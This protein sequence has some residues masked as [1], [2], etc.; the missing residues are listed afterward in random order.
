MHRVFDNLSPARYHKT[1]V[2]KRYQLKEGTIL[3]DRYEL[4]GVLGEG[5]FGIT[6]E[7]RN[8]LTRA[9]VAIKEFFCRDYMDRN[10]GESDAM[11]LFDETMADRFAKDKARFLKEARTLRDFAS[12]DHVV[13]IEEYFELNGTAYIVMAYLDGVTLREHVRRT[14]KM[15]PEALFRGMKPL[16]AAL[17]R[18]HDRGLVHRDISP[19][20]IMVLKDGALCL[21][22]FGAANRY[23]RET[24]SYSVICKNGYA[25]PEQYR[26]GGTVSPAVD[27]Y[28]LAAT[29]YFCLTGTDPEDSLQRVLLDELPLPSA[30]GVSIPTAAEQILAAALSLRPESRFPDMKALLGA[31]E[32]VYPE[33]DNPKLR[34]KRLAVAVLLIAAAAALAVF[35]PWNVRHR[36]EIRFRNIDTAVIWLADYS[37]GAAEED[38]EPASLVKERLEVFAGKNNYLWRETE[39]EVRIEFPEELLAGCPPDDLCRYLLSRPTGIYVS[40]TDSDQM[41]RRVRMET[42]V[43]LARSRIERITEEEGPVTGYDPEAHGISDPSS[44]RRLHVVLSADGA[45]ELSGLLDGE[46]TPFRVYYD[47]DR[48]WNVDGSPLFYDLCVSCGD[49]RSFDLIPTVQAPHLVR[50]L[51]YDL[52]HEAASGSFGVAAEWIVDWEDPAAAL[53][54]GRYQKSRNDLQGAVTLLQYAGFSSGDIAKGDLYHNL[55]AM[56]ERLDALRIPYAVGIQSYKTN[57]LVIAVEENSLW[58]AEALTLGLDDHYMSFGTGARNVLIM[59]PQRSVFDSSVWETRGTGED[60]RIELTLKDTDREAIRENLEF[61]ESEGNDRLY[62]SFAG[63]DLPIA[64]IAREEAEEQLESGR[65]VFRE[66]C[67]SG[68]SKEEAAASPFF[69]YLHTLEAEELANEL[70]LYEIRPAGNDTL[71]EAIPAEALPHHA[72]SAHMALS[73]RL[74]ALASDYTP[75]AVFSVDGNVNCSLT[76][77]CTLPEEGFAENAAALLEAFWEDADLRSALFF[78]INFFFRCREANRMTLK[79]GLYYLSVNDQATMKTDAAIL[80]AYDGAV[81]EEEAETLCRQINE[82]LRKRPSLSDMY[83]GEDAEYIVLWYDENG[84]PL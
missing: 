77:V 41:S 21:I 30:L 50:T 11:F 35:I 4:G 43:P 6:Y 58:S 18:I 3:D 83:G 12:E 84:S 56:K 72:F 37:A 82:E 60:F 17:G 36:T 51:L 13:H 8:L 46:G 24:K 57:T 63:K 34:K 26:S 67:L 54:P 53:M 45:R 70:N 66:L 7:G 48:F 9:R 23:D 25:P 75:E 5:G 40:E 22:D 15:Q 31:V 19:D 20:N 64:W 55:I 69:D 33:K 59:S 73:E 27:I 39:D 47:L 2:R 29:M 16:M 68:L 14:G 49:G 74:K 32:E 28:A 78:E 80:Q 79:T 42:S 71:P 38:R 10:C 81:T 52:T 76:V 65:L 61:W 1:M 62:F 44:L